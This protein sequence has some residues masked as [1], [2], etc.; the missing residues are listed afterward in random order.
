MGTKKYGTEVVV[1]VIHTITLTV[2]MAATKARMGLRVT[3]NMKDA[4]VQ[5][6]MHGTEA[7][8][9]SVVLPLKFGMD[10]VVCAILLTIHIAVQE[11]MKLDTEL[12][13]KENI[14]FVNVPVDIIGI[15]QKG[16]VIALIVVSFL[17]VL[18]M[19]IVI[20]KNVVI[21]IVIISVILDM[22]IAIKIKDAIIHVMKGIFIIKTEP[23]LVL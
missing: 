7:N 6:I 17:L 20:M 12:L 1:F 13:V 14:V 18:K 8:A 21:S 5:E 9:K 3:E 16:V 11:V 2:V 4:T 19:L 23:V 10:L 22:F 15:M